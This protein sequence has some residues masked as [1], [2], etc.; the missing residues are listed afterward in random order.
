MAL[1]DAT[2][3]LNIAA[4]ANRQVAEA[5]RALNSL[6]APDLTINVRTVR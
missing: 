2:P 6:R 4:E 1:I 5:Q 3:K